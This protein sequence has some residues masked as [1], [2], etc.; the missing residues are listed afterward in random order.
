MAKHDLEAKLDLLGLVPNERKKVE[1][2]FSAALSVVTIDELKEIKSF[3]EIQGIHITKAK[4]V[5]V[6][7]TPK[8]QIISNC[9]DIKEIDIFRKDPMKIAYNGLSILKIN[10]RIQQ[11]K[12]MGISYKKEDGIYE[13]FLFNEM[14]WQK[15]SVKEEKNIIPEPVKVEEEIV[16]LTPE[17]EPIKEIFSEQKE[18]V[19]DTQHVDIQDFINSEEYNKNDDIANTTTFEAIQS[20][21]NREIL[22]NDLSMSNLQKEKEEL[23]SFKN[24]LDALNISDDEISFAELEPESFRMGM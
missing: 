8:Q 5:K 13:E 10:Q 9:N 22:D 20:D 7:A 4:E 16:T 6:F 14:L 11:C 24:A 17:I 12:Q 2:K 15:R 18:E 23:E 19:K 21:I 1:E 3:L